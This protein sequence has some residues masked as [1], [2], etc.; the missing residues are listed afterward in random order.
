M[1]YAICQIDG[2]EYK[3]KPGQAFEVDK[4]VEEQKINVKALLIAE[5]GQLKMGK[6]FLKDELILTVLGKIKGNKIR[7]GKYHS[8]SNYRRVTGQRVEKTRLIW[9]VKSA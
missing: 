3:I 6:P 1:K 4:K 8:K 7:V 5:E 9:N 2:K